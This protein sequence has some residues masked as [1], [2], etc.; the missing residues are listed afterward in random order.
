MKLLVSIHDVTPAHADAI[1]ELWRVC[2]ERGVRP[3]LLVVPDWH[4]RWPIERSTDFL[5]W[6][7]ARADEGC[8]IFLHGE[9]HDEV[10]LPRRWTDEVRAF[11]RTDRE[12][13]FLTL[14]GKRA[15]VKMERGLRRLRGVGLSPIG[16][17][18]PAWLAPP[19]CAATVS[20]LGLSISEDTNAIQLA[21]RGMRLSSPVI[22]WSARTEWRARMSAGVASFASWRHRRHW[23]VR[24]ALHPSDLG[25]PATAASIETTLDYWLSRRTPWTYA[26]L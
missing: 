17:V 20:A 22:R 13:E 24:I 9:R 4:G 21:Q 25:H 1:Q 26:A 12:G 5:R 3:A 8:E 19:D 15:R 18:A 6:T 11:G 14:A 7:R 10:G 16:F 23:L 2:A